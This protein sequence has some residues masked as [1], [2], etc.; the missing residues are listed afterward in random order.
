MARFTRSLR[1]RLTLSY[2]LLFTFLLALVG[3]FFRGALSS[4]LD[5][6][7]RAVLEEEWGAIKGYLWIREGLPIWFYDEADPE[8]A[9]V[10]DRLQRVLLV[11]DAN[12]KVL[13]VSPLYS[14][15]GVDSPEKIREAIRSQ[16]ADFTVR[17]DYYGAPYLVRSGVLTE[18]KRQFYVAVGR[19]LAESRKVLEQFTLRYF[20]LTPLLI[21]SCCLVGW[22][23][24]RRALGPVNDV[25]R[26]AQRISGSHLSVRIPSRGADDELDR[27][28]ESFNRMIARLED[29]FEQIR[30]F[31][32][33]VSHELRTPITA[34]RGQLEVALLTAQSADQFR[35]AVENA[36]QDVE[37]LSQIVRGLL[38][39]AQA[40]SGQLALERTRLDFAALVGDVVEQFQI[41][42][43][44]AGVQLEAE[45]P[46]ECMVVVDRLQCERLV[47]NLLSNAVKYTP[48]G[49]RV[50]VRL[51]TASG[52]IR[53]AVEDTGLGIAAED[54]P[55]I[56]D[57]FY[58][59]A[60]AAPG[61]E[62]GLGLGLSFVA[63]IAKAHGGRVEVRS[64]VGRGSCFLVELPAEQAA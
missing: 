64:V 16:A 46:P 54:I 57:R 49:G 6:Q 23:L 40:E 56:F 11:A 58:R 26:A 37:R 38:L 61:P 30:R 14:L 9:A 22:F 51:E 41:P 1:Y 39:L 44:A 33:D 8:E 60:Y 15:I 47:S 34:I 62:R 43:E 35:E 42:A 48:E 24:A 45:L 59:S 18:E 28:I 7:I 19:P 4:I 36:M 53:L 5:H 29:S 3:V 55:H 63:W 20:A 27:L 21:L 17:K 31:S 12:G 52:K 50:K 32:T 10:V 13:E 25:A 2:V